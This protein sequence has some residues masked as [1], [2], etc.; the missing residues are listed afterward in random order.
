MTMEGIVVTGTKC[1]DTATVSN[2]PS[3][4]IADVFDGD[5]GCRTRL[6]QSQADDGTG[7]RA[8]ART[9]PSNE[10]ACMPVPLPT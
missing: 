5:Q 10:F 1:G 4:P 7:S 2:G 6:R 3:G 8:A 9:R